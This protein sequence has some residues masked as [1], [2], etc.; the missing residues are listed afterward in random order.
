MPSPSERKEFWALKDVSFNIERG[1]RV[2]ILGQNGA[3][4]STLLK[5]LSR[6]TAPTTGSVQVND[7][8]VSLLEIG[9]GFHPELTG[10]ENIF[11]NGVILGMKRWQVK[12]R[13]DEIVE[14]AEIEEFLDMPVKKYS[15]GMYM[16]LAFSVSAH[17][18]PEIFIID[19]MLAVGDASFQK[20][21]LTRMEKLSKTE[22][23]TILLVSHSIEA[24]RL[25]CDKAIFLQKGKLMAEGKAATVI[26]QYIRSFS[27]QQEFAPNV[28]KATYINDIILSK[29][30]TVFG[31]NFLMQCEIMSDTPVDNYVLGLGV[32][33]NLDIRLA[34][35]LVFSKTPLKKGR[36]IIEISVPV[37]GIVPGEYKLSVA[38]ANQQLTEILDTVAGYP[39]FK[40]L[41]DQNNQYLFSKWHPSWG[42]NIL[43]AALI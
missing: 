23:R 7:K 10:R 38:L 5:I 39:T 28:N 18:D 21:C 12:K 26:E 14:F 32:S 40:I 25:L 36:N 41:P 9:A 43:R 24:I 8:L 3:G 22:G 37:T 4:K 16:R 1:S 20:K 17:L 30:E 34:S 27:P 11:L 19:E 33:N 29:K 6:I 35:G 31:E 42:D 13:F 15:T 2:G